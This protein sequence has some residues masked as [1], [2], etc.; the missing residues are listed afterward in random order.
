MSHSLH[1]IGMKWGEENKAFCEEV[2][3]ESDGLHLCGQYFDFGFD[4]AMIFLAG[5]AEP[6]TYGYF[7]VQEYQKLGRNVLVIDSRGNGLS[8]G[9]SICAGLKEYRDVQEWIRFLREE[10]KNVGVLIHGVCLGSATGMRAITHDG[11][12]DGIDGVVYIKTEKQLDIGEFY[13]VKITD[14]KDYDLLGII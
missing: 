8:E 10:K 4:R 6:C 2:S 13:D 7:F 11:A 9:N 3:I 14:Y 12:P 1:R 5:R